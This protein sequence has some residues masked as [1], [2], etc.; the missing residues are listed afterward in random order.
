MTTVS[1]PKSKK[2]RSATKPNGSSNRGKR[3]LAKK[4]NDLDLLAILGRRK[5]II[6]ASAVFGALIAISYMLLMPPLYQSQSRMLLMR[7]DAASLATRTD[8][9]N[10][11]ISQD[12]LATHMS[13]IQSPRIVGEALVKA[14]LTELA[15][16][17]EAAGDK[18]PS[19]YVLSNLY[20]TR[21]GKGNAKNSHTLTVAFRHINPEDSRLVVEAIVEQ[22]QLFVA[23]KFRDINKEAVEL[24]NTARLD[25]E[26]QITELSGGYQKFR[27]DSPLI[28]SDGGGGNIH[29]Q[30]FQEL[31][32]EIDSVTMAIDENVGRLELVKAGLEHMNEKG[33]PAIEKLTLID[34]KNAIRLGVLVSVER[35]DARTASFLALQPER[36]VGAQ[37]EYNSLLALK[38]KL[39]QASRDFGPNHTE[40]R[41]LQLQIN[42][43]EKFLAGRQ[44]ALGVI[45]EI[46]QLKPDDVMSAYMS[47]LE[48]DVVALKQRKTDLEKQMILAEK[49]SKNMIRYEL[50][51]QELL[52][53]IHRTEALYDSVVTRLRDINMQQDATALI[54]EEIEEPKIGELV[55]PNVNTAA[56]IAM[57]LTAGISACSILIAELSDKRLRSTDEL[58][59]IY[60]SRVLGLLPNFESEE[61]CKELMR[62]TRKSKSPVAASV[63]AFHAANDPVSETIRSIRTQL[64]F[65]LGD[66]RLIAIT[67]PNQG[68]G[69]TT[70]TANLAV[71][72]AIS[73]KT[74]LVIDCDMRRPSVHSHFGL[75][76]ESGLADVLERNIEWEN[77][78]QAGP[79]NNLSIMSAG[80][81]SS[82]PAELLSDNIFGE[83]LEALK[84]KYDLVILDCPPILPVADPA[85]IAPLADGVILVSYLDEH[86]VPKAKHCQ[87]VL[88]STGT[89]LI[90]IVVNRSQLKSDGYYQEYKGYY[91]EYASR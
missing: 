68:D 65:E 76:L 89:Q 87:R 54:Q 81:V 50:E 17:V 85:I 84:N 47:L 14:G 69:K 88:D 56:V 26:K 38:S 78:I 1:N 30:R 10:E 44:S 6:G 18:S 48:T 45:D 70:I 27:M 63:I 58:E 74:V 51:D 32:S 4:R 77:T 22:Y 20:V 53:K 79:I 12:M 55:S 24:I 64:I 57:L 11:L 7:S 25:L 59:E 66:K 62:K 35:G 42:E 15:S 9:A 31:A 3:N 33:R 2:S 29:E 90:G 34:E 82:R 21:G 40:V 39:S 43:M 71:S 75:S 67:S 73:G 13:L 16:L 41:D 19:R 80:H 8:T 52:T 83:V 28:T 86:S 49:E 23:T 46:P 36:A 60:H 61:H 37:T 91:K 5:M 72:L